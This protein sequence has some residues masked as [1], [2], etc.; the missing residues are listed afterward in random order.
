MGKAFEKVMENRQY[1]TERLQ[2]YIRQGNLLGEDKLT[3]VESPCNPVSMKAYRGVNRMNLILSGIE[4]GYEDPRWMTFDQIKSCG[5]FLKKGSKGVLC[6]YWDFGQAQDSETELHENVQ[7]PKVGYYYVYNASDVEGISP[8]ERNE[9]TELEQGTIRN[10][11]QEKV[12]EEG[13]W[14][15]QS[16]IARLF[17]EIEYGILKDSG[18]HLSMG[19]VPTSGEL[20]HAIQRAQHQSEEIIEKYEKS[21]LRETVEIEEI[22]E[23]E[24]KSEL[25]EEKEELAQKSEEAGALENDEIGKITDF[26][27][28]IG[29]AKKDQWKLYGLRVQ[30]I[31]GMNAGER[32]KYITKDN[33]WKR[34]DYEAMIE[35]GIPKSV[36]WFIKKVRDRL[37][38]KPSLPGYQEGYIAFVQDLKNSIMEVKTE[39][40]CLAFF[41]GFLVR[42]DY[43]NPNSIYGYERTEKCADCL[44]RK[45]YAALRVSE[46]DFRY[47]FEREM[48]KAQFGVPAENKLP[49]GVT[50]RYSRVKEK[51]YV[52]KGGVSYAIRDTR[53]EAVKYAKENL[54][55]S[56]IRKKT[57]VPPQLTKINRIGMDVVVD[58]AITGQNYLDKFCFYGGEFGNWMTAADRQQSLNMGYEAFHDLAVALGI[59]ESEIS[60]GGKLAIAFGSRGSGNAVAHYE[61]L[62]HVINLTKMKG[63]GSLAHEWGHAMDN[64]LAEKIGGKWLTGMGVNAPESMK[65]LLQTMKYKE[66]SDGKELTD[67]YQ[68]SLLMDKELSK[69]DKGYWASECEMFA[70]AFAC[71]VRDKLAPGVSDYLC[72]HSEMAAVQIWDAD[73]KIKTVR[74][75]PVGEERNRINEAMDYLINELKEKKLLCQMEPEIIRVQ[76]RGKVM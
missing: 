68:N 55:R 47:T 58:E 66:G 49:P 75:Y 28:K 30:D 37:R 40:D 1:M 67:F 6:E 10:Y 48:E 70:R 22:E 36:V 17:T 9:R 20:I 61:S 24:Q 62:R 71:Y 27:Q 5:Y 25:P 59:E 46:I 31:A 7:Q 65:N 33:I 54:C 69:C 60:L 73:N 21:L 8:Y 14:N 57:F 64:I 45:L 16:E 11:I 35:E 29:G 15:L 19:N 44:D 56:K 51:Y 42:K 13:E 39:K 50:I 23:I 76:K 63:A 26:G 34:P 41:S 2:E 72:G 74:A 53:E 32:E 38:S 12:L 43:I 4:K 18:H 52:C 3:H